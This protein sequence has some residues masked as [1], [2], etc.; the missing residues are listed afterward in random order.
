M[1][2]IRVGV[3]FGGR[4]GE[5]EV[6]L[7]SASSVILYLNKEKYEVIPIGITKQGAWV[8]GPDI[9]QQL[10]DGSNVSQLKHLL[11]TD[12]SERGMVALNN[13][14]PTHAGEKKIPHTFTGLDV[15]FPVL[16]GTFGEDGTIQG[17]FEMASVA[18][19]GSGVVGSALGMD[20]VLQKQ[21]CEYAAFPITRYFFFSRK[22]W[23]EDK[24]PILTEIEIRLKYPLFVKPANLG[25]SVGISKVKNKQELLEAIHL[26]AR[27]DRK[28]LIE[29]GILNAREIEFALLGNSKPRIS[30]PGEV[31][32]NNEFYDYAAKYVDNASKLV[33]PAPLEPSLVAAMQDVA[34]K[35]YQHLNLKGLAR[36]DFLLEKDSERFVL[37]EF[38]T[39][40]G[41][42][43]ISMFPKLWEASGIPYS[44]LLDKLIELA[45]DEFSDKSQNKL[46]FESGD[47]YNRQ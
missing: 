30:V 19:V 39:M 43:H 6:S 11:S 31:I 28:I 36:A 4:S 9:L 34:K 8:S 25:S 20:K 44:E 32:P 33:I 17:L 40:P 16:H 26:A 14:V 47:W 3:I 2:K 1:S 12:P 42:T 38:N 23:Q 15:I 24:N 46:S 18:Y 21:L 7:V 45:L 5:H 37:N 22:Q 29:E 41:F 13:C 10:K 35:A 27:Y